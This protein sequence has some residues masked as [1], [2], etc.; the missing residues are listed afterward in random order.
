MNSHVQPPLPSFGLKRAAV[1]S[2]HPL[3]AMAPKLGSSR[4]VGVGWAPLRGDAPGRQR[5]STGQF[6]ILNSEELRAAALA[7]VRAG[8]YAL[9]SQ[10]G[11]K[12]RRK[13]L[14]K[15]LQLWQQVP[16]PPTVGKIERVAATLRYGKYRSASSYLG[17]YRADSEREG[18]TLDGPLNRSFTDM[19]RSCTR[20]IGAPIRSKALPLER[21]GELPRS[22]KPWVLHGPVSPRTAIVVGA[23]FLT[24][25]VELSCSRACLVRVTEGSPATIS[26]SL[27]ASKSDLRADGVE[28]VHVCGC[29]GAQKPGCPVC[30]M[31]KHLTFLRTAF[32]A[33][34]RGESF[35]DDFPLFPTDQGGVCSKEAMSAT[36][37]EAAKFL[38]VP[39]ESPDGSEVISGH[40]LRV[41]GAQGLTRLGLELWAVQLFGRWGRRQ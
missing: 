18:Y 24:R 28:R 22:R 19:S 41:T 14:R 39:L 7:A 11:V 20:G 34:V 33:M 10:P 30:S 8:C 9:S 16:F 21:L 2:M 6:P 37:V 17:Q 4:H 27:P 13:F 29:E 40:T 26:W 25:E 5:R 12:S 1:E 32:P 38:G 15:A 36:L 3:C 35:A 23:W 31:R